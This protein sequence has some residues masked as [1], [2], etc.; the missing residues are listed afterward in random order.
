M[1]RKIDL[2]SSII[3]AAIAGILFCIPVYIF[4]QRADYRESWL[5]YMGSFL[6]FIAM[7]IHTMYDSRKRRD[8]ESTVALVFASHVATIMGV[9][10]ASVLSFLLLVMLVPGYLDG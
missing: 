4:I 10:V 3:S 7:W 5:L 2:K 9:V 6:F 8:N 1:F